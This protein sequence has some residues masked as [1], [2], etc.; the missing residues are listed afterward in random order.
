LKC[1]ELKYFIWKQGKY[2]WKRIENAGSQIFLLEGLQKPL[3]A[4]RN[5]WKR[6]VNAGRREN[7]A[8]RGLK[9]LEA[10]YFCWKA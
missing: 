1:L 6:I 2:S 4:R 3:E 10:K 7:G 5:L 8:G 9:T